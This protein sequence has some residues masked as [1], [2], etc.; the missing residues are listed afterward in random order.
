MKVQLTFGEWL[1][2]E[3]AQRGLGRRDLA[4]ALDVDVSAVGFWVRGETRPV[5][6]H[7]DAIARLLHLDPNDVRRRAGRTPT[8]GMHALEDPPTPI[9]PAHDES[10]R[11]VAAREFERRIEELRSEILRWKEMPIGDTEPQV[12]LVGEVPTLGPIRVDADQEGKTVPVPRE[13][14]DS[15]RAPLFA[16]AVRGDQFRSLL[17]ADGDIV[18]CER[19]SD[20]KS[21]VNR[22]VVLIRVAANTTLARWH[23]LEGAI[24][25]R[26]GDDGVIHQLSP[27]DDYEILGW[28]FKRFTA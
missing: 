27:E 26:D 12:P 25:L 15:A 9:Q 22:Q 7:C 20:P 8:N 1:E 10:P 18:A 17:I 14:V 16:V 5:A 23:Q 3:L 4:Q 28:F 24:E 21:A 6:K 19:P 11:R 13:W 2:D